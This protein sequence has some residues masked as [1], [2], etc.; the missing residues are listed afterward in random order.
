M[1]MNTRIKAFLL[2]L[3]FLVLLSS[4]S[5]DSDNNG[6]EQVFVASIDETSLQLTT[7]DAVEFAY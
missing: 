6:G 3:L 7:G 1:I 5:N 4:C 2:Y